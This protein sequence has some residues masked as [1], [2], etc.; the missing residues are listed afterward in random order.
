M[1]I[2]PFVLIMLKSDVESITIDGVEVPCEDAQEACDDKE[3]EDMVNFNNFV[4][5]I[6]GMFLIYSMLCELVI[7]CIT[8]KSS[9]S[10]CNS[11][12]SC[13]LITGFTMRAVLL[14]SAQLIAVFIQ[15]ID[16]VNFV[17]GVSL[18]CTLVFS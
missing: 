12:L 7:L 3:E 4:L 16:F 11:Y 17:L 14:I 1:V 8:L 9:G 15:D 6:N 5:L 13:Q 2:V 10:K 18:A